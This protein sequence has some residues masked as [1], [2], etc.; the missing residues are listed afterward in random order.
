MENVQSEILFIAKFGGLLGSFLAYYF[1]IVKPM[2]IFNERQKM[3][4]KDIDKLQKDCE[5]QRN[6]LT[7]LKTEHDMKSCKKRIKK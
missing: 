6:I 2:A 4:R 3:N 5:V 1:W 7:V